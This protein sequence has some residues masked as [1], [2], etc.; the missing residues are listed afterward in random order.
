MKKIMFLLPST[1]SLFP[2]SPLI[3]ELEDHVTL[4]AANAR[5]KTKVI[6][7]QTLSK[8]FETCKYEYT[9]FVPAM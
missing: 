5:S 9:F 1:P 2:E 3:P 6:D 4:Q 8:G 7:L